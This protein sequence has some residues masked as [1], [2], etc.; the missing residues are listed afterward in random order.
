MRR[1]NLLA[2]ALLALV[3]LPAN[4]AVEDTAP[5]LGRLFHSAERRVQL[6][7]QRSLNIQQ[8]QTLQG[9]TMSLDG[10]VSRS[11]G[12]STVWINQ[13]AQNENDS[14][15]TG[16]QIQTDRHTPTK[17]R[18]APGEELATELKVGEAINRGTG[19]RHDVVGDGAVR[20]EIR[21]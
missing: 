9:A 18:I 8:V 17:A 2:T 10:V 4:A 20:R 14:A 3:A 12:K 11:S 7:R 13:R 6:E 15:R 1:L 19:Q 16:M 5:E 21:R